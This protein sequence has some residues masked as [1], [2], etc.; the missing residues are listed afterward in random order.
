MILRATIRFMDHSSVFE[1]N[2]KRLVSG[3]QAAH[4][5]NLKMLDAK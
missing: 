3:S 1:G 5:N 4:S 2:L